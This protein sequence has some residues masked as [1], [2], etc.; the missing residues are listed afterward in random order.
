VPAPTTQMNVNLSSGELLGCGIQ[1]LSRTIEDMKG[2]YRDEESRGLLDQKRSSIKWRLPIRWTR[3][4]KVGCFGEPHFSTQVVGD[5]YFMTKGYHHA[6]RSRGEFYLTV[7]GSGAL[8]LM[9]ESRKTVFE[10]ISTGTL[11]YVPAYAAHR[12]ANTG[13]SLLTVLACWPSDAGHDYDV[14]AR[15]GFS[16]CLRNI[17][18][19][20]V[21]VEER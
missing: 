13:N 1:C 2:V 7:T 10:P 20:P 14:N 18:G 21:L 8:I 6:K 16:A 12:I 3:A 19:C 11:H 9:D 17:G 4:T 15:D 5:E